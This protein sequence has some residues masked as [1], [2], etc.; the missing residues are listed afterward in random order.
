M[1]QIKHYVN[2]KKFDK[3]FDVRQDFLNFYD[4]LFNVEFFNEVDKNCFKKRS[5]K[6]QAAE[7]TANIVKKQKINLF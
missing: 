6:N 7:K 3:I 4:E 5:S 1:I 2:V